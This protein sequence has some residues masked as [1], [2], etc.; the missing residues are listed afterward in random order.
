MYLH[1]CTHVEPEGQMGGYESNRYRLSLGVFSRQLLIV[2]YI[3]S[4][5][6]SNC[7]FFSIRSK[8]AKHIEKVYLS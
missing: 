3:N 2:E 6:H 7:R 4:A 1:V 8:N 5:M